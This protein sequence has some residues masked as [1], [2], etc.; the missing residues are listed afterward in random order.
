MTLNDIHLRIDSLKNR[1]FSDMIK[2]SSML[3]YNEFYHKLGSGNIVNSINSL[4]DVLD[5]R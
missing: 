3:L 5:D 1:L 2:T 4:E